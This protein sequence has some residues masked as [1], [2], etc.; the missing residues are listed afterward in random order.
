MRLLI[1]LTAALVVLGCGVEGTPTAPESPMVKATSP[2]GQDD[3]PTQ[4][5]IVIHRCQ[6]R[7]TAIV[8][9]LARVSKAHDTHMNQGL[10]SIDVLYD[11]LRD[12]K[13][14]CGELISE[15][16]S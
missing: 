6:V 14:E 9:A 13:I 16:C 3:A 11:M 5:E 7:I 4:C 10:Q 15:A 12:A 2:G 8:N 1:L